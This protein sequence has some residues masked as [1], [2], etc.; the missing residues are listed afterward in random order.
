MCRLEA[1]DVTASFQRP[2]H[3]VA[4]IDI[5]RR[6]VGSQRQFEFRLVHFRV[7]VFKAADYVDRPPTGVDQFGLRRTP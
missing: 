5:G 3:Q 2:G 7:A 1:V 4:E 6:N